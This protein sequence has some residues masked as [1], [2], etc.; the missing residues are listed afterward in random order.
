MNT[1]AMRPYSAFL[2]AVSRALSGLFFLIV[3]VRLCER[4]V[5]NRVKTSFR[6]P[7]APSADR[8]LLERRFEHYASLGIRKLNIGGGAKSL[9]GFINIDF[10]QH[11]SVEREIRADI[12][13][14]EFI[15]RESV[16]QIHSNHVLE[17]LREKDMGA[18]LRRYFEVL[19]PGGLLTIRCPNALGAAF[20]FWFPPVHEQGRAEFVALGYPEQEDFG[21]AADAWAHR[22]LFGT[23]HWFFGD[24]G[25]PANQHLSVVTPSRLRERVA[26]AGFRI[27]KC[28]DPEALNIVLAAVKPGRRDEAEPRLIGASGESHA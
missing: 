19:I 25:N 2:R 21:G 14:L 27:L 24:A 20:A 11:P 23:L 8:A 5:V 9:D 13:D 4:R 17:H 28:T 18:Q 12:L 6:N 10:V 16:E 15:P 1:I 3:R 22:D 7:A 26:G